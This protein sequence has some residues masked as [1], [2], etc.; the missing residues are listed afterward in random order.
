[1]TD[2]E[3]LENVPYLSIGDDRK[4]VGLDQ[5]TKQ[6]RNRYIQGGQIENVTGTSNAWGRVK[7]P[8]P[9]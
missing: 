9:L 4:Q 3:G 5:E 8:T 2:W 7:N 6:E 1:M